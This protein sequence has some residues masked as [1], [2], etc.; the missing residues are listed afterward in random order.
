MYIPCNCILPNFLESTSFIEACELSNDQDIIDKLTGLRSYLE[1]KNSYLYV[2]SRSLPSLFPY[3]CGVGFSF[4]SLFSC[5]YDHFK[6]MS[7]AVIV[8]TTSDVIWVNS[9]QPAKHYDIA[10]Q[11][12]YLCAIFTKTNSYQCRVNKGKKISLHLSFSVMKYLSA[13]ASFLFLYI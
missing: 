6:H 2:L 9:T 10:S 4:F 7:K 11:Y 8:F 12:M 13:V 5:L 3:G 1:Y